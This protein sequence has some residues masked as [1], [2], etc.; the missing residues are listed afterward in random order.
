MGI[1]IRGADCKATIAPEMTNIER[2]SL[3][4]FIEDGRTIGNK[5]P[6]D[7]LGKAGGVGWPAVVDNK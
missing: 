3:A 2:A 4:G 5:D 1:T 7:G 6:T